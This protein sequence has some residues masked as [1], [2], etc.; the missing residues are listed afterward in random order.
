V[1]TDGQGQWLVLLVL[2]TPAKHL[3][4]RNQWIGWSP[5][6]CP[7]RL[8]LMTNNSRFLIQ[9]ERSVP[10][11]ASKV[12]RLSLDRLATDWQSSYG[13]PVLV[14][15]TFVDVAQFSGTVYSASG[16]SE[17]GQTD[18]WGRRRRDYY[19]K[20]DQPKRLFCRALVQKRLPQ[21]PGRTSQASLS[22][23]RTKGLA[24]LYADG[25]GNPFDGPALQGGAR[26]SRALR[27]LSAVVA[28]NDPFF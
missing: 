3:K 16:C 22:G 27:V 6:Q 18:G 8:S 2:S 21:S 15:E 23:G 4:R 17:L 13:H 12:L 20:H 19:V 26:L 11:L 10:N 14:V 28:V 5:A 7:R 25:Q 24:T 1:A 9:P